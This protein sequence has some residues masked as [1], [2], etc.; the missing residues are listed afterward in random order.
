MQ[1]HWKLQ[2]WVRS[3]EG[4]WWRITTLGKLILQRQWDSHE[5][6]LPVVRATRVWIPLGHLVASSVQYAQTKFICPFGLLFF[7]ILWLY[8]SCINNKWANK[9][10]ILETLFFTVSILSFSK[11]WVLKC[12]IVK[13]R[14][15]GVFFGLVNETLLYLKSWMCSSI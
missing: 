13:F 3:W 10:E 14:I 12:N 6:T 9:W 5:W 1:I 8:F 11:L 15:R 2:V 7:V 4:G